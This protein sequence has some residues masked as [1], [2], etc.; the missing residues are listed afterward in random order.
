MT[1]LL[2]GRFFL[3]LFPYDFKLASV[4]LKLYLKTK[5]CVIISKFF[6]RLQLYSRFKHRQ[7]RIRILIIFFYLFIAKKPQRAVMETQYFKFVTYCGDNH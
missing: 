4:A 7:D 5:L 3:T 6:K 2:L 1:G